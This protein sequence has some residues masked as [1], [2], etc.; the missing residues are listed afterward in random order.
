MIEVAGKREKTGRKKNSGDKMIH[1]PIT[2]KW[3]ILWPFTLR[4][5]S[6]HRNAHQKCG[7]VKK[8]LKNVK[9][10]AVAVVVVV[11]KKHVLYIIASRTI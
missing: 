1:K 10:L 8:K 7:S 3:H 6:I 9:T 11:K 2:A 4:M 5:Q